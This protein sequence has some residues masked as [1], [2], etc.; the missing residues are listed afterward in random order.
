L[1]I[2]S[3]RIDRVVALEPDLVLGFSD[4]QADIAA[5][6]RAPMRSWVTRSRLPE[7]QDGLE[8][9]AGTYYGTKHVLPVAGSQAAIQ[10]WSTRPSWTRK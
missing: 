6:L 8:A 10:A 4:L 2:T 9:V 1:T 7:D 3:A 5:A